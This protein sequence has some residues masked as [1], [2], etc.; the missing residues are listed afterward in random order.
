MIALTA[1][2]DA[3]DRNCQRTDHYES[4]HDG[5]DGGCDCI[6]LIIGAI[7]LAGGKWS[8]T[9]G[10]NWARRNAMTTWH[11]SSRLEVGELVY[12]AHEPGD[13]GYNLP[14]TYKSSPDQR[15]YYHVGVVVSVTPLHIVHCT[16]VQGGI[17]HDY[18]IGA[19]RYA[20]RLNL[21]DY[22]SSQPVAKGYAK[23]NARAVALREAPS[24]KSEVLTRIDQGGI[25]KLEEP[26][27]EWKRVSC[28][29]KTGY[30]MSKFLVEGGEQP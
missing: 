19:W 1:F 8:G 10:S 28:N 20:G 22:D 23:V 9:H 27:T 5:S 30:M 21:I 6:G 15:D 4:G 13:S 7:R 12:K 18:T 29:G 25:V 17:K 2:M 24:A 3:L 16:G 11:S 26:D 14:A